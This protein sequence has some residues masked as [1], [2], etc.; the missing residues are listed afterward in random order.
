MLGLKL[1]H[2]SKRG[3]WQCFCDTRLQNPAKILSNNHV[4]SASMRFKM[5]IQNVSDSIQRKYKNIFLWNKWKERPRMHILSLALWIETGCKLRVQN[6]YRKFENV[7]NYAPDN[8][9][10]YVVKRRM[11][12]VVIFVFHP[13]LSFFNLL[14]CWE[15]SILLGIRP[16]RIRAIHLERGYQY[17]S[18][19]YLHGVNK[20]MPEGVLGS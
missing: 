9:G 5:K 19:E 4:Y 16:Q 14:A 11:N 10:L 17:I 20:N 18:R 2:V 6:T 15:T 7:P 3:H 8:I 12:T 13:T 1:N